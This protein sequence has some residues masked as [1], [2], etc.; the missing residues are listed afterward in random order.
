MP[1]K[2][3]LFPL[4]EVLF[5]GML[6]PLHI[7]EP[8]YRLMI[9]RCVT[10]KAPFGVVLISKGQEVG[11]GAEFF[12]VGTTARIKSVQRAE[13]GRLYIASVGEQRFRVLQTFTDQPYLEGEVEVIPE[14]PGEGERLDALTEQALSVLSRYLEVLTGSSELGQNLRDKDFS[15]QHLS[16]TIATLLQIDRGAKQAILEVPT[17][18][19]RLE[20]ELGIM[21]A[22]LRELSMLAH[23]QRQE[24]TPPPLWSEN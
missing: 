7:F 23:S 18:T 5:P 6:L 22:E 21:Q 13:D 4:S 1:E 16:Y 20:H 14:E 2:L 8:R 15:P 10:E 11:P 24:A 17:T 3:P 12:N 19:A 9:N